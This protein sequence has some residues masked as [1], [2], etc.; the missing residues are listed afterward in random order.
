[1]DKKK[2][3]LQ[4]KLL[5]VMQENTNLLR[6][7]AATKEQQMKIHQEIKEASSNKH[8]R[9]S[10]NVPDA[11]SEKEKLLGNAFRQEQEIEM[12][13]IQIGQLK[14]KGGHVSAV[15]CGLPTL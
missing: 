10:S 14:T 9:D 15:S 2:K 1:M 8:K 12:L 6:E 5:S 3:H 13:K 11:A 7:I 4:A